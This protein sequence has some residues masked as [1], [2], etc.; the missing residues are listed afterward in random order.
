MNNAIGVN[1]WNM[2]KS[3]SPEPRETLSAKISS[4]SAT[5]WRNF[6]FTHGITL[7]AMLEVAGTEL[8]K[9]TNPPIEARRV[10]IEKAREIDRERRMRK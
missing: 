7:T 1:E 8:S 9:E 4:E 2:K 10:M 6:C 5:G 3:T